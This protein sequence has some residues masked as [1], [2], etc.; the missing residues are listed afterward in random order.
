[1]IQ[2]AAQLAIGFMI[3]TGQAFALFL[4]TLGAIDLHTHYTEKREKA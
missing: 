2:T 3:L 1:M 4:M